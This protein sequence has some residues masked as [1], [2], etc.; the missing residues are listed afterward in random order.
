[1]PEELK[2]F[3]QNKLHVTLGDVNLKECGR[4]TFL[5]KPELQDD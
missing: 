3:D 5:W 4:Y 2:K 1:M